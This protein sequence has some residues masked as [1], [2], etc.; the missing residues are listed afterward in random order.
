MVLIEDWFN[1]W[2]P[3]AG[4]SLGFAIVVV[5]FIYMLSGLLMNERMKGWAKI[6]LFEVIYSAIILALA[7]SLLGVVDGFVQGAILMDYGGS[8]LEVWV[9]EKDMKMDLCGAQIA[10]PKDSIYHNV[11]GCHMRIG[12]WYLHSIFKEA[13]SLAY[14][15]YLTY[16]YTSM[17]ADFTINYQFITEGTGVFTVTPW[18][19]FF[20][21]G[22]TIKAM[23][24]D[25]A[26]KIMMLTKFQEIL[27]VF[28][29]RAAFPALFVVGVILRTFGFSRKLGGLLLGIAI[30]LYYVFPIFYAFGG[31]VMY[32][33]KQDVQRIPYFD[34]VCKDMGKDACDNPPVSNTMYV[35]GEILMPGGS[36]KVSQAYEDFNELEGMSQDERAALM[37]KKNSDYKPLKGTDFANTLTP[38]EREAGMKTARKETETWFK[39][40]EMQSKFDS[41]I[42]IAYKEGGPVD[43]LSRIAFFS[44][45]F[46]LFG[47]LATIAAIRSLSVTFGG[48][49]EIAG[50]THLI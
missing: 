13:S 28:I 5:A 6:E 12:I 4:I 18:R 44:A 49:I 7:I 40:V 35:K 22:N 36:I 39:K 41:G 48:D 23:V 26:I 11:P 15:T 14:K 2:L 3:I 43:A 50:L 32:E 30:S 46:S 42:S 25:Y 45:F 20:S 9:P 27:L 24:F 16:I 29:S 8:G 37:E 38:E 47:I 33:M 21:M 10:A 17:A 31:L 34:E 19:G 1:L